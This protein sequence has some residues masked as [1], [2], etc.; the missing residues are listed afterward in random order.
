MANNPCLESLDWTD[1]AADGAFS[2][3][4]AKPATD[5][6]FDC[7]YVYPTV[8]QQ[9]TDNANLTVEPAEIN[10]AIFQASRFSQV[11]SV[12]AP[13][14]RQATNPSALTPGALAVAYE[15]LLS[16]WRD[17]ITNYNRGR[18]IIFISHSQGS[19][20]LI[21]LLSSQIDPNPSLRKQLV[22]AIILGGNVQVPAGKDV[23]GSFQNIPACRSAQ[24]TGCV[25]AYSTFYGQP[26]A[27]SL[28]GIPGRGVSVLSQQF[29]SEGMEVLCTNPA[30]L[31][32]GVAPLHP[33]FRPI[34]A[35]V[36]QKPLPTAWVEYPGLY[37]AQCQSSGGATWLQVND[38]GGTSDRRPRSAELQGPQWGLH[39]ADVNIALGDLVQDVAQQEAAFH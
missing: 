15:S 30:N 25:I 26:P 13:M 28:F 11:C 27:N 4:R 20:L 1:V 8:S 39:A 35:F 9:K 24:Q 14:Y 31:S 2:V 29:T 22:S 19:S 38:V 36:L 32:G 21:R 10:V 7:F 37:T 5:A 18:P 17:Y 6:P 16:G 12:W 33:Y 23:G 3:Q 34:P